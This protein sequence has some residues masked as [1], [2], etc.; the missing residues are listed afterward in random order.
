MLGRKCWNDGSCLSKFSGRDIQPGAFVASPLSCPN[1]N[2]TLRSP[3]PDRRHRL[4]TSPHPGQ[5]SPRP[6]DGAVFRSTGVNCIPRITDGGAPIV[7]IAIYRPSMAHTRPHPP[8]SAEHRQEWLGAA[9][10]FGTCE[11]DH[12]PVARYRLGVSEEHCHAPGGTPRMNRRALVASVS[13]ITPKFD[14]ARSYRQLQRLRQLV[15]EAERL[16]TQHGV[17]IASPGSRINPQRRHSA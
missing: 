13:K 3:T 15:Q 4:L 10:C 6:R 16:L 14:V 17:N 8:R 9:F 12:I 11:P 2:C 5:P 1:R 7:F